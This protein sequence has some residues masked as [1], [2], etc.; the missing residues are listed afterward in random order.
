[1]EVAFTVEG[2]GT[3]VNGPTLALSSPSYAHA[4]CK[5]Y[6]KWHT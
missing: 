2:P 5:Y 6:E 3:A 4:R 1:M